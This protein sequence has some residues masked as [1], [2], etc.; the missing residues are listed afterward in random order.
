MKF[1][2]GSIALIFIMLIVI[3][4]V[5]LVGFGLYLDKAKNSNN[6]ESNEV[7][8]SR[9]EISGKCR[10]EDVP[11]DD[12]LEKY[13]VKKGDTLLSIAKSE[14]DNSSRVQELIQLNKNTYPELSLENPFIE[15][16]WS[17]YLP[18]KDVVTTG[19]LAKG[20][21]EITEIHQ[22]YWL[23][24]YGQ[25][26]VHLEWDSSTKFE[27]KAIDQYKEGDCITYLIDSKAISVSPQE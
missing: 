12:Y 24:M 10:Y 3:L 13:T 9:S 22:S 17:F 26:G 18:P 1:K 5:F 11:L 14:L 20:H 25:G 6:R 4:V 8:K 16:G 23:V 21:G 7:D 15:V 19:V 27:N 2:S